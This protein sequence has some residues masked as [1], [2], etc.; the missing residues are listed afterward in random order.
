M[1]GFSQVGRYLILNL[2]TM[3][4]ARTCDIQDVPEEKKEDNSVFRGAG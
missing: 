4:R 2:V 1:I 3:T